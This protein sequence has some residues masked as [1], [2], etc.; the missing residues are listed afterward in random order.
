MLTLAEVLAEL[1]IGRSTFD[2]W[3]VKGVAPEHIKLPNGQFRIRRSVLDA[4]L[5]NRTSGTVR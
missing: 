1:K 3:R 2:D 5:S 4:W